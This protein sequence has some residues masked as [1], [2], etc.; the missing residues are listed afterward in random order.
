MAKLKQSIVQISTLLLLALVPIVLESQNTTVSTAPSGSYA[1]GTLSRGVFVAGSGFIGADVYAI[2]RQSIKP[3]VTRKPISLVKQGRSVLTSYDGTSTT[4]IDEIKWE[5][6]SEGKER[7]EVDREE[8]GSTRVLYVIITD[9]IKQ[10][11]LVLDIYHSQA[12]IIHPPKAPPVTHSAD[13]STLPV[14]N[15]QDLP[16]KIVL[17]IT[18]EGVRTS[19][20]TKIPA[21]DG[22]LIDVPLTIDSWH[23]H[24]LDVDLENE[25][26]YAGMGEIS[27]K[28]I[29]IDQEEPD[30]SLFMVPK[31]YTVINMT[32]K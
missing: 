25:Y 3:A 16:P 13:A 27:L 19:R 14:Q 7:V 23:S 18:V 6:D 29:K 12:Q 10:V 9:P 20:S 26:T 4:T 32:G 2:T 31:G 17:G 1:A 22:K 5:R 15:K 11:Y 21:Q 24:E 30:A 8:D 28:T